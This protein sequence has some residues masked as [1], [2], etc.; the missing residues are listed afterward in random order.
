M[1]RPLILVAAA[2]LIRSDRRVLLTQRPAGKPMSGLWEFPGG[3][4][5]SGETPPQALARELAEEI[6]LRIEPQSLQPFAFASHDYPDFHLL[7]PVFLCETWSGE[8]LAREGQNMAWVSG[9]EI[10]SYPAPAADRAIVDRFIE[11]WGAA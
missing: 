6:G 4:V 1:S 9:P 5:E 7:M 10:R 3:K 8:P 2:A 11:W